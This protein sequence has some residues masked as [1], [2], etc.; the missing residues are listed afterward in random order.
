MHRVHDLGPAGDA[1]ERQAAGDALGGRD[2]VGHDALVVAREHVAGAG[3]AALDLVGDEQDAVGASTS[4][5]APAGSPGAGT[6]NPPSPW[7][8]SITTAASRFAP[9]C[10]SSMAIAR[11]GRGRRRRARR[12]RNGYD[13]GSAVDLAGERAEAVLVRHVLRRH[14]HRE[15]RAA[16]VGV[17]EDDDGVA[18]RCSAR[19]ILTAFSTASA[20]ELN[21]AAASRG[22]RGSAG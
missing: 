14:R 17:V 21:S 7:I 5:R 22:R 18:R 10:F 3:E 1:G 13:I 15:V 12:S 4:R 16:V 9:T 11:V 6:T 8:G 19:A 2:Q 20:P